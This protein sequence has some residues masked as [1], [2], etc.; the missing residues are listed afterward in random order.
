MKSDLIYLAEWEGYQDDDYVGIPWPKVHQLV[1]N[2]Q[3]RWIQTQDPTK[4]Q[5]ILDSTFNGVHTLYAE[6]YDP[7]LR[8][9][10]ALRFAK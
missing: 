5:L 2:D 9:E 1:G 3:I 8:I 10:Y 6:F 7:V 4:C